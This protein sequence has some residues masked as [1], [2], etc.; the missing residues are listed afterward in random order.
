MLQGKKE[1]PVYKE[2]KSDKTNPTHM[3]RQNYKIDMC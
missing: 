3:K 1:W 2:S